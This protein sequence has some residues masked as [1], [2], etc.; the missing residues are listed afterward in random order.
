MP[1]KKLDNIDKF[2]M[3]NLDFDYSREIND[4]KGLSFANEGITDQVITGII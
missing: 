3:P 4:L 1:N 2:S